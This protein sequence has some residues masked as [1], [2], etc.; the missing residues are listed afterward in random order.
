LVGQGSN[1]AFDFVADGSDSVDAE[2][3]WVVEFPV[4][5]AFAGEDGQTSPQPM[6]MMTS[7]AEAVS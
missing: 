1:T 6:V 5:V 7:A 2:A 3:G 4:F